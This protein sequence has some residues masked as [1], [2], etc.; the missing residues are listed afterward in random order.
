MSTKEAKLEL[1]EWLV[2]IKDDS[3]IARLVNMMEDQ[4]RV[5]IEEYNNEIDSA[6][7]RVASGSFVPHEDLKS[8]SNK[9]VR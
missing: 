3:T 5:S 7:Q 9:W 2:G 4:K 6:E 1:I 8:E